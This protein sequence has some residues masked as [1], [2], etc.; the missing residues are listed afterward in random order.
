MFK[1]FLSTKLAQL[2]SKWFIG[3]EGSLHII[4]SSLAF[5]GMLSH[6]IY[7]WKIWLAPS[8]DFVMGFGG[9]ITGLVLHYATKKTNNKQE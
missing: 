4:L 5:W 9:I 8:F 1:R 2:I 3:S 6:H 7:D